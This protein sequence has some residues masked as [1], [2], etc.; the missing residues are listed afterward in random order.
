M[1]EKTLKLAKEL[2]FILASDALKGVERRNFNL[3]ARRRE[4]SAEHSWQVMLF[5]QILFP[6]APQGTDLLRVLR[7]LSVHDLV[8][9]QA[10]DTFVFDAQACQ[11]QYEREKEAARQIFGRLPSPTGIEFLNLWEEFEACQ[12]PDARYAR[13]MDRL[14]PFTLNTFNGGQSWVEAGVKLSQVE[15]ILGDVKAYESEEISELFLFLLDKAIRE[16]KLI[17]E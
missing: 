7:M 6:Y 3:D 4:N 17:K 16:E 9:I 15:R 11:G 5:A 14:I 12:T 13:V 8:E 1:N 10:G 2:D